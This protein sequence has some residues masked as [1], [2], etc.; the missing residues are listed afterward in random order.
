MIKENTK[1]KEPHSLG[2]IPK[3][4][5]YIGILIIIL[6]TL[7]VWIVIDLLFK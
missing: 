3:N 4:Y 1:I 6:S 5:I 7:L 2:D